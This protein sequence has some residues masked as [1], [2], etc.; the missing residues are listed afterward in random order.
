MAFRSASDPVELYL[1]ATL[2][3]PAGYA[4]DDLLIVHCVTDSTDIATPTGWTSALNYSSGANRIVVFW[5]PGDV[6]TMYFYCVGGAWA[7]VLAFTGRSLSAPI[8]AV[9][10]AGLYDYDVSR[11][12][13]IAAADGDDLL[14]CYGNRGTTGAYSGLAA[15]FTE[16][17]H[18]YQ[19]GGAGY[20][21]LDAYKDA[22]GAGATG[23]KDI[24]TGTGYQEANNAQVALAVSG[25]GGS[26][27]VGARTNRIP[28]LGRR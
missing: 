25:G 1:G 23:N 19:T 3:K 22:V 11:A 13:S 16:A 14:L 9:D 12:P 26:F 6:A 2:V 21:T 27:P 15:G 28:A 20:N 10:H 24:T 8:T 17:K 5:A 18:A 4:S 7:T